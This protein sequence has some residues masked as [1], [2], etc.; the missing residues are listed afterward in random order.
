MNTCRKWTAVLHIVDGKMMYCKTYLCHQC[1]RFIWKTLTRKGPHDLVIQFCID[2]MQHWCDEDLWD[3]RRQHICCRRLFLSHSVQSFQR[4][5]CVKREW[6]FLYVLKY[7]R[8]AV[9][10]MSFCDSMITTNVLFSLALGSKRRTANPKLI[11]KAAWQQTGYIFCFFT[12]AHVQQ[13]E[14]KR[15]GITSLCFLEQEVVS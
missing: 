4:L 8:L 14:L 9:V 7:R 1:F 12:T 2:D 5:K 3:Y 6:A 11:C 13:N 10:T 15:H